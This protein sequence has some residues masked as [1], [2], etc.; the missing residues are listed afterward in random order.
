MN[1]PTN[2]TT[3]ALKLVFPT[4]SP[5]VPYTA[6]TPTYSQ[7]EIHQLLRRAG[8]ASKH[9]KPTKGTF[10]KSHFWDRKESGANDGADDEVNDEKA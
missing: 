1:D 3:E 7:K 9:R 8:K 10:G 4:A 5:E 2:I 6:G